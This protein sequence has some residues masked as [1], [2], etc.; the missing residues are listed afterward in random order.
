MRSVRETQ[1][2]DI[3]SPPMRVLKVCYTGSVRVYIYCSYSELMHFMLFGCMS[4]KSYLQGMYVWF[5]TF[6]LYD[7]LIRP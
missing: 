7:R 6:G 1:D 5:R 3:K 4:Y 2:R